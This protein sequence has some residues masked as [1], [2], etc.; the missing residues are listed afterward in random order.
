[1]NNFRTTRNNDPEDTGQKLDTRFKPGKS[2][3]PAGRPR[4]SR[5]RIVQTVVEL[6]SA[7]LEGTGAEDL[8]RLRQKDLSTYWR[9]AMQFVPSK[10]ESLFN[11]H[12]HH[13]LSEEYERAASFAD[14]WSVLEKARARIGASPVIEQDMVEV[15][16]EGVAVTPAWRADD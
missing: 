9:L 12:V 11:V 14:A 16:P 5:N 15:A 4:G 2:G 7:S 1:M 10:V 8:E 6:Y 13:E 3:N